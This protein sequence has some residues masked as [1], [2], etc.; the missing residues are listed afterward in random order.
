MQKYQSDCVFPLSQ[1]PIPKG[2]VVAEANGVI[3]DVIDPGKLDYDIED[4]EKLNGLLCP[5][6]VNTHAH[7]ELS[8]LR[9]KIPKANGLPAFINNVQQ[10]KKN[11]S[12]P[13]DMIKHHINDAHKMMETNGIVACGDVANTSITAEIKARSKI[14]YHTF[15]ELYGM[16]PAKAGLILNNGLALYNE[17][18][19]ANNNF[20]VSITPH[21]FY[22]VSDE[23]L[24]KV[25]KHVKTQKGLLSIH[26]LENDEEILFIEEHKGH[27]LKA[28][29]EMGIEKSSI[30]STKKQSIDSLY[31]K[32]PSNIK[33][34]LVHNT[35]AKTSHVD[36][37]IQYSENIWWCLCPNSNLYIENALPDFG[38]FLAHKSRVT[39]GTDSLASNS[40]LSVLEELKTIQRNTDISTHQ[41]LHWGILNGAI[42]LGID[43]TYGSLKP[44]KKP[45]LICIEKI[46]K[47]DFSFSENASVKKIL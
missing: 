44:G 11:S 41:L 33:T 30:T 21:A 1:D 47:E 13:H 16:Q 15:I 3:C 7:L 5:G 24:N 29:K 40:R 25:Y 28:F 18:K 22:S 2:I 35:F 4:V 43:D 26:H 37:A 19:N 27:F 8:Y 39:I 9:N 20:S 45:G 34:L 46:K 10:H 14:Y 17:F 31:K 42:F 6:F 36:K 12:T 32:I 38:L 23:L